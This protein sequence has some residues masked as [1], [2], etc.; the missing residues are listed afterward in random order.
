MDQNNRKAE[1]LGLDVP[2]DKQAE[3]LAKVKEQA[4]APGRLMTD[5][6]FRQLV[7]ASAARPA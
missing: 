1:E 2:A 6:E 5:D 3:L 4:N 7:L